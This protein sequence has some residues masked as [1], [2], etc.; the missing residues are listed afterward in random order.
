MKMKAQYETEVYLSDGDY[1]C[2]KQLDALGEEQAIVLSHS[3]VKLL[4]V[5]LGK[6]GKQGSWWVGVE[7]SSHDP[8]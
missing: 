5:E 6:Y 1:L 4:A 3:Q 7:R 8:A 2:I